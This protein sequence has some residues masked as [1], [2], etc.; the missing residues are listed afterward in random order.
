MNT[1]RALS[2]AVTVAVLWTIGNA[3]G[4][5]HPGP[6]LLGQAPAPVIDASTGILG[7]WGSIVSNL[8]VVGVLIWHLWY[9]V[10]VVQPRHE[11]AMRDMAEKFNATTLAMVEN[12]RT[13]K[14]LDV[15]P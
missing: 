14:K 1:I 4:S 3:F 2:V 11:A 5:V 6:V 13:G 7:P 9:H 10:S 12:C 8:G 15:S